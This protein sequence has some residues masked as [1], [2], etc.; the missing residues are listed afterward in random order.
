MP[1]V[2]QYNG[3]V[4]SQSLPSVRVNTEAPAEAFGGG[5]SSA[6]AFGAVSDLG[7]QAHDVAQEEWKKANQVAHMEADNKAAALETQ[8]QVKASQML[9]KDANNAP[10]IASKEW[11]DGTQKIR[12]SLSNDDQ[13]EAFD[14]TISTRWQSLDKN[15]QVH[16][17]EQR[18][19][20]DNAETSTAIATSRN[21]AVL[22][23]NDDQRIGI[24]VARQNAVVSD[25][26]SRNGI[27]KDSDIYKQKIAEELSATHQGVITA[28][29]DNGQDSAARSYFDA[30]KSGMA[31][32]DVLKSEKA[33]SDHETLGQGN[34]MWN[35]VGGLRLADGMPDEAKMQAAVNSDP[36]LSDEKKQKI[37]EVVKAKAGESI[38]NKNR[39]D[40]SN[41][42][43]FMDGAIQ[44]RQQGQP[45]DQALKLA[46]KNSDSLYQQAVREDAIKK[47]Y[48]PP[49][50]SDPN[51]Y[52]NLWERV[53]DGSAS[54]QEIDQAKEQNRLNVSDWDSLRKDYY[55]VTVEGKN[56]ET[57]QAW[58][59][60]GLLADQ[61]FGSDK[62]SK[63]EFIYA[64][65]S[66]AEGKSADEI[67]KMAKDKLEKDPSTAS[68]WTQRLTL[69]LAGN[70][71]A[72]Y[73]S[74]LAK[75]QASSL[76]FGKANEDIGQN[77]LKAIQNGAARSG[78]KSF[79]PSDLDAFSASLG[80][81]DNIKPGTPAHNAMQS[82][83]KKN[84]LVTPSNI[85]AVL[86]IHPDGN[87]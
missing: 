76:A 58:K 56:P 87:Y 60:V 73:K 44:M 67:F 41:D 17:A 6:A 13:R 49:S 47:L 8:L 48:A 55:K 32:A 80:G 83:I 33:I 85:K 66:Q 7:K 11:Q 82:L 26:A 72:Q 1:Q 62:Q 36:N 23:A 38:A 22:N 3:G 5:Q 19:V 53:Q 14:R 46:Q 59:G 20:Y 42:R 30:N 63:N 68:P 69:G 61:Q 16:V 4:R 79:A 2:P 40:A 31:A 35:K 43:A 34:A 27:P 37:W 86:A 77:T 39:Q 54:K 71:D 84:Q 9:G 64:L 65:K 75:Q 81:Y 74:D 25:W 52:M 29:L 78:K 51:V 10:D 57:S 28:R 15:V 21:A 24:E 12:D 45:L 18:K 70:G 50:Q